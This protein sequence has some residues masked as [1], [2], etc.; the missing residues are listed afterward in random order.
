MF[1]RCNGRC[2]IPGPSVSR[3]DIARPALRDSAFKALICL[4]Q[5]I[6]MLPDLQ[7]LLDIL[8]KSQSAT[9]GLPFRR[10]VSPTCGAVSLLPEF[11]YGEIVLSSECRRIPING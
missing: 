11:G 5:P 6:T 1:S 8:I 2:S 7:P 10:R 9:T 4:S 3:R